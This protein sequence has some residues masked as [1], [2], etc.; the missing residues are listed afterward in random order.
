MEG[1]CDNQA[2]RGRECSL[3][4]SLPDRDIRAN[5]ILSVRVG[6]I[7]RSCI[8]PARQSYIIEFAGG[9]TRQRQRRCDEVIRRGSRCRCLWLWLKAV[10]DSEL[11][12]PRNSHS[13]GAD[14]LRSRSGDGDGDGDVTCL[15]SMSH[16]YPLSLHSACK[17]PNS[18][19]PSSSPPPS[20][21]ALQAPK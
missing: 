11:T 10:V 17:Y 4:P 19:S 5:G 13:S 9:T 12:I 7:P 16:S 21:L 18:T 1:C 20:T 15:M 14:Y 2:T 3:G 6:G 8:A